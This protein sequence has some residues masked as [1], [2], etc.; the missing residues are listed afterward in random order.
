MSNFFDLVSYYLVSCNIHGPPILTKNI[1]KLDSDIDIPLQRR[2]D[3]VL[4]IA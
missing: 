3:D 2:S 4:E 1:A